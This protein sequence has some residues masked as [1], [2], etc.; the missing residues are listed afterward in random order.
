MT[1]RTCSKKERSGF[2]LVE[3]MVVI[4]IIAVLVAILLPAVQKVRAAAARNT[5]QNNLRQIALAFLNFEVANKGF[6]RAGEHIVYAV[7]DSSGNFVSGGSPTASGIVLTGTGTNVW[8]TQDLQSPMML[9]LPFMEKEGGYAQYDTRYPYND[10]RAVGNQAAAKTIVRSYLCPTNPLADYR[11]NNGATDS[12]GFACSDYTTIPYVEGATAPGGTTFALAPTALTGAMYPGQFYHNFDVAGTTSGGGTPADPT[13]AAYTP[14]TPAGVIKGSKCVHLDLSPTGSYNTAGPGG[15][16][17]PLTG[18]GVLLAGGVQAGAKIDALFGLPKIQQIADGTSTSAILYEDVGRNETMD[19]NDPLAG[20]QANEYLDPYLT[21]VGTTL[22]NGQ[23]GANNGVKKSHWRYADPDT[24]SG[25]VQKINSI[26]GA[27]MSSADPNETA[28]SNPKCGGR[29]WRTHDCGP[30]NEGFS[31]HG[32]GAHVA[33]A[34]GHVVFMRD[35]T[36]QEVLRA[37]ATRNNA[38]NEIGLEYV[39]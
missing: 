39:D 25:M 1:F 34:D 11:F 15:T 22:A 12:F 5:C 3:L 32:G 38:I 26:P 6:P 19:G 24:A 35:S 28:T 7:F 33:F 8:K 27:S 10:T 9:I 36:T 18:A 16:S 2:T 37:I 21:T 4:A 20:P 13:A 29:T 14:P 23:I 30:H 17:I 31:F